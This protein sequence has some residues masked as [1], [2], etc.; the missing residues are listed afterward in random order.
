[1]NASEILKFI[2]T[3]AERMDAAERK[4]L[5]NVLTALRGPDKIIG[6]TRNL[7]LNYKRATTAVIRTAALPYLSSVADVMTAVDDAEKMALRR[8]L[9]TKKRRWPTAFK[10]NN[11][12]FFTHARDAFNALGLEWEQ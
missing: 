10:D 6:A 7:F 3:E 12:H 9:R 4:R 8:T 11:Q 1:M 5:W 2:D